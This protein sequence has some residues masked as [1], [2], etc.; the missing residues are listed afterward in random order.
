[1]FVPNADSDFICDELYLL[2]VN[3]FTPFRAQSQLLTAMQLM[4]IVMLVYPQLQLVPGVAQRPILRG[5][6][7]RTVYERFR[8]HWSL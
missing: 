3:S 6:A 8:C 5:I 1:M 7:R 2:Y 4:P